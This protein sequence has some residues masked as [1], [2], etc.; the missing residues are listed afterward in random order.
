VQE[1]GEV[2]QMTFIAGEESRGTKQRV[3]WVLAG[4]WELKG[5]SIYCQCTGVI[6]LIAE[7]KRG[8]SLLLL[9]RCLIP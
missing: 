1:S 4:I 2:N 9:T 5:T 7:S 8:P 3:L 6:Q